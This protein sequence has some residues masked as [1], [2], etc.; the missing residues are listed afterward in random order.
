[1]LKVI[2]TVLLKVLATVLLKVLATVLLKVLATVLL[3]VLAT[4]FLPVPLFY[5]SKQFLSILE[6]KIG[7]SFQLQCEAIRSEQFEIGH[8]SYAYNL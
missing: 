7:S 6:E 4:D 5:I 3:K 8:F 1:M 2:A